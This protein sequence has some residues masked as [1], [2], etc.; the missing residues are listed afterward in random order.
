MNYQDALERAIAL[1]ANR[2]DLEAFLGTVPD[3]RAQIE[4]DIGLA[5]QFRDTVAARHPSDAAVAHAEQ[6]LLRLVSVLEARDST[7]ASIPPAPSL[8]ARLWRARLV[9]GT[10]TAAIVIAASVLFSGPGGNGGGLAPGAAEAVLIEG[11]VAQVA[12]QTVTLETPS[13]PRT[14]TLNGTTLQDGFGNTIDLSAL[15]PGQ[16]VVLF[17]EDAGGGNLSP[18]R[19]EVKDRLFGRITALSGSSLTLQTS[20]AQYTIALTAQ[21]DVRD[22]VGVGSTVEVR[23]LRQGDGTLRAD[24]IDAEDGDDDDDQRDNSGPGGG[25]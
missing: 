19:L 11:N 21:T 2:R 8:L 17:A 10:A 16:P 22:R 4:A 3:W 25:R 1:R 23:V 14:F 6:Q 9:V 7:R 13:G 18:Q 24:R 20:S 5:A 15:K 12:G